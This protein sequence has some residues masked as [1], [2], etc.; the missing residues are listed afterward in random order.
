MANTY[1]THYYWDW[2]SNNRWDRTTTPLLTTNRDAEY[3]SLMQKAVD[4]GLFELTVAPAA[5]TMIQ[6]ITVNHPIKGMVQFS[7]DYDTTLGL[8]QLLIDFNNEVRTFIAH[9]FQK[10][11]AN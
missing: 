7:W 11:F 5:S 8:P 6:H 3:Q 4:I 2:N 9:S 10:D 1:V